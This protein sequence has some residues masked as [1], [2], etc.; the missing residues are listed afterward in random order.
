MPPY[1]GLVRVPDSPATPAPRLL[2]TYSSR[3]PRGVVLLLHGGT[4]ASRVPASRWGPSALRML[5]VAG[6]VAVSDRGLRRVAVA[7]LVNA[8][9]GWNGVEQSPVPD[10]RWALAQLRQRWPGVPIAVVGHSMGGRVALHVA[11]E[12]SVAVVIGL[13]PWVTPVE[14]PPMLAGRRVILLHG[15][16]DTTTNP[17]ASAGLVRRA[18][19][20]AGSAVLVRL[21]GQGH[22]LLGHGD[23]AGRLAA[24]VAM[25]VLTG[26]DRAP[27]RYSGVL[28][29][30]LQAQVPVIDA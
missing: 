1:R 2:M 21:P 18:Q 10:A 27:R 13:A 11:G 17:S 22:T 16:D 3:R 19:G 26:E 7:R 30:A 9:Q 12:D 20:V 4:D 29:D 15:T 24:A 14:T 8:L 25:A 5:P 23:A 28:A 6:A